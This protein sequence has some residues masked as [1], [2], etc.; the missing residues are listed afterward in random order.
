[1]DGTPTQAALPPRPRGIGDNDTEK[2]DETD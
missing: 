2:Y 1:M